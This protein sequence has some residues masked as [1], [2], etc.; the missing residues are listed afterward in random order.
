MV[1]FGGPA[2]S[3]FEAGLLIDKSPLVTVKVVLVSLLEAEL[4]GTA[5]RSRATA[6]AAAII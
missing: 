5:A 2:P 3:A 1:P 6:P 4:T